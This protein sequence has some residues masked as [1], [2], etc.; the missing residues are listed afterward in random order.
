MP[1]SMMHVNNIIKWLAAAF[2]I[3]SV[4]AFIVVSLLESPLMFLLNAIAIFV[5]ITMINFNLAYGTSKSMLDA[6]KHRSV[7]RSVGGIFYWLFVKLSILGRALRSL[8]VRIS[9]I[10]LRNHKFPEL[11]RDILEITL[12]SITISLLTEAQINGTLI[13]ESLYFING[14]R[15]GKKNVIE[16]FFLILLELPFCIVG[17]AIIAIFLNIHVESVIVFGKEKFIKSYDAFEIHPSAEYYEYI[18]PFVRKKEKLEYNLELDQ[19]NF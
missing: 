18:N 5:Y 16:S 13:I 1:D 7:D 9:D 11:L 8:I 2:L 6:S 4:T 12:I 17:S 19:N 10:G 14:G 3:L 15:L